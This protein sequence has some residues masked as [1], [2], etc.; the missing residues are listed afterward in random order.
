MWEGEERGRL[1]RLRTSECRGGRGEL[2]ARESRQSLPPVTCPPRGLLSA[3]G[4]GRPGPGP[5]LRHLLGDCHDP[6]WS[7]GGRPGWWSVL[8]L[9][10]ADGAAPLGGAGAAAALRGARAVGRAPQLQPQPSRP[11]SP[12]TPRS[13][14]RSCRPGPS[15][16]RE[17]RVPRRAR[18]GL[19]PARPQGSCA[20][21]A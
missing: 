20:S 5:L 17:P 4:G 1:G 2:W 11:P 6:G 8:G 10:G 3:P 13:V 16:H 21:A 15:R 14:P 19:R 12:G 9:S 7:G 18:P